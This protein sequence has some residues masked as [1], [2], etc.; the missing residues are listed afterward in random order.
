MDKDSASAG[1]AKDPALTTTAAN[2]GTPPPP[3]QPPQFVRFNVRRQRPLPP[4]SLPPG[5]E[6]PPPEDWVPSAAF[7]EYFRDDSPSGSR[8][9]YLL[10]LLSDP[11]HPLHPV[12]QYGRDFYEKRLDRILDAAPRM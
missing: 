10:E 1:P 11:S 4:P 3:P 5:C 7:L 12:S 6:S 9:D 8:F 2:P